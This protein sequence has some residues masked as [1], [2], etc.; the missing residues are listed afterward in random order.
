MIDTAVLKQTLGDLDEAGVNGLLEQFLAGG[1]TAEETQSVVEACQQGM[2]IVGDNFEAGTYFVGDLM[3]AAQIL[4]DALE[5]LKP[6]MA[7]DSGSRTVGTLVLG[8]VEGDI[9][10]IG[11]NIYKALSEAAGFTVIDIGIDQ[12]PEAFVEAAKAN[13]AD[14]VG[15]SGVL[16]LSIA[17]MKNTI[18]ALKA[19]GLRDKVKVMIGGNA[20][21]EEACAFVG[22]DY[23]SKNAAT[24]VKKGMEYV[25]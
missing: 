2:E 4:T 23:W 1:P 13:N 14:I 6:L 19:A 24:S 25:A 12:K 3:Y 16:T 7:A 10:D 5:K 11:K 20:V 17:S 21:S 22:A 9:H 18:E 15:L 8:T